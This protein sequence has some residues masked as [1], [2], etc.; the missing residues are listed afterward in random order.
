MELKRGLIASIQKYSLQ[1]TQELALKAIEGG[2]VGIRTDHPI[3]I[4]CPVIGLKKNDQEYYITTKKEDLLE[5]SKWAD[6]IAI[7]SRK[8]NKNLEYLL[9]VSHV[10]DFKIVSDI[11][12]PQDLENILNICLK[13]KIA[14]PKA[15]ATTFSHFDMKDDQPNIQIIFDIYQLCYENNL[16]LIAEGRYK[17]PLQI[18]HAIQNG[19]DNICIGGSL[20]IQNIIEI[21]NK[22]FLLE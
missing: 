12:S 1:T 5:V 13:S 8:G 17:T 22:P 21:F 9:A 18:E 2:A 10:A 14:M 3:K 4:D 20:E 19:A 15:I 7:D 6:F 16:K 11:Q